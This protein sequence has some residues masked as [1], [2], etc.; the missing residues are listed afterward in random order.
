MMKNLISRIG[1]CLVIAIASFG[2]AFAQQMPTVPVDSAVRIG[3][4]P[5]GLTYYIRHNDYPKGQADFYIAQKVGSALE[6]D[7][8]RG[9]AH[10]LEHMCFNGTKNFPGNSLIDWLESVGVKFGQNLNAYTSI[11]ETVYNIANVPTARTSV[12]DSCLL[13]LHDW[14]DALLLDPEEIDK[15]RGVIHQEWRRSMVGSMRIFEKLLPIIYPDQ[16]HYGERLPIGTMEVVDNFPPQALRDYYEAWYRPDQQGIVV[17]GDI[18]E[19]YIEGKIKEIFSDIQMPENAKERVYFPVGDNDG[20]I[21]AIGS[22]PEMTT[23]QVMMMFKTDAI[24]NAM[25]ASMQYPVMKYM[26]DMVGTMLSQRLDDIA[27]KPDAPF[28]G[29]SASYDDFFVAKT[30]DAFIATGVAKGDDL[31]PVIEAVYRELLRAKNGGFTVGE[32]ERAKSEYLSRLEKA[33][34]GRD[35]RKNNEFV[36]QYVRHFIDNEPIPSI[37][38]EYE[39]MKQVVAMLPVDAINQILPQLIT[40]DN[41]VIMVLAPENNTFKVPT[42]EEIAA[43]IANVG[44]ETIEPYKDEMKSEPLIPALPTPGSIV[45]EKENAQWDATDFTLS[46]GVK[47]V[48]KPTKFKTNEIRFAAIAKGGTSE[49]GDEQAPNLKFM[50]YAMTSHGLGDYNSIDLKKYLQGKQAN[51]DISFDDYSR[52]LSGNTTVKDLPTLMEL[53]YMTF[54]D[55]QITPDD[56][57]STQNTYAGILANQESNPQYIFQKELTKSL[58]KSAASQAI[59]SEDIMAADREGLLNIIHSQLKNAADYTFF[60][61]GDID[62]D[63]LKPLLEQYIA[64]IPADELNVRNSYEYNLDREIISGKTDVTETTA[65]ETPQT[66]CAIIINGTMD[67][68]PANREMA[69]MVGQVLSNRLLKKIREEMGAVYSIG[70]GSQMNRTD[71]SNTMVQIPFPMKPE[72][73]Q[74]VLDEINIILKDMTTNITDNELNPIKEFMLKEAGEDFEDNSAW[75]GSMSATE[76]NGVDIFNGKTDVIN[77]V[78]TADLTN[79]FKQLL[80]QNNIH[81]VILDPKN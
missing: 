61:V 67:Y 26:F 45:S 4:L 28:A 78:S 51:V 36:Q 44:S 14:A 13:I 39:L 72:M 12:Q 50:P 25:K 32:Y 3:K 9:L 19:D 31:L 63:T 35:T 57:A 30:K 16:P 43:V 8:Q 55:Y 76:L 33:Y 1:L 38:D 75:I 18:D 47:V 54:V 49:I 46:N 23:G 15:E 71:K 40:E 68:T 53:I 10:F 24:P 52:S 37:E 6:E 42:Q 34:D 81:T 64:T 59:T 80:D 27:Q 77:G 29:A 60:F 70:A 62:M 21:Y 41:R 58:T 20:T 11:D 5:N 48:V 79:F 69:S 56:F 7:N 17:V 65:M 74:Q 22:D 2:F 73:K 66:W